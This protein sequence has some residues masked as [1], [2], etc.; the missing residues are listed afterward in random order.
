MNF[1]GTGFFGDRSGSGLRVGLGHASYVVDV[2]RRR[3]R[4]DAHDACL[5]VPGD[6]G[7][8]LLGRWL[9]AQWRE[10]PDRAP[11]ILRERYARGE[12]NRE[13]FEAR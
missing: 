3:G 4:D 6:R 5:L 2:G 8:V 11:E 7:V 1:H 13:E 12:M 9:L 10:R